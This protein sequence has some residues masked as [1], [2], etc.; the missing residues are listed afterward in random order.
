MATEVTVNVD[1]SYISISD[2]SYTVCSDKGWYW[3]EIPYNYP[4][5]EYTQRLTVD[6]DVD[7]FI[8]DRYGISNFSNYYN[9][10]VEISVTGTIGWT[11]GNL[12]T[13]FPSQ[14]Y[15][16]KL[17]NSYIDIDGYTSYFVEGMTQRT[18]TRN[19]GSASSCVITGCLNYADGTYTNGYYALVMSSIQATITFSPRCS[20][21]NVTA[22]PRYDSATGRIA[23]SPDYYSSHCYDVDVETYAN[24]SGSVWSGSSINSSGYYPSHKTE[25]IYSVVTATMPF[26]EIIEGRQQNAT[27]IT[28]TCTISASYTPNCNNIVVSSNIA[29]GLSGNPYTLIRYRIKELGGSFGSWQSSG[30]FSGTRGIDYVVESA[31][32]LSGD[33]LTDEN[34]VASTL[35]NC[36]IVDLSWTQ[37][38]IVSV[39]G[40]QV[41]TNFT[42]PKP[43]ALS[44]SARNTCEYGVVYQYREG[45]DGDWV[46]LPSNVFTPS[47]VGVWQLRAIIS[48][49]DL[50]STVYSCTL[51]APTFVTSI[52]SEELGVGNATEVVDGDSLDVFESIVNR[53]VVSHTSSWDGA[54][55][56]TRTCTINGASMSSFYVDS[57]ITYSISSEYTIGGVT[58]TT[59]F[60]VLGL[61]FSNGT[62]VCGSDELIPGSGA[63]IE[64]T[65][66]ES[67]VVVAQGW[68]SGDNTYEFVAYQTAVDGTNPVALSPDNGVLNGTGLG[69]TK[70]LVPYS[71]EYGYKV[72]LRVSSTDD[73]GRIRGTNGFI[74]SSSWFTCSVGIVPVVT[75]LPDP[76]VGGIN[77]EFTGDASKSFVRGYDFT[78]SYQWGLYENGVLVNDKLSTSDLTSSEIITLINAVGNYELR[79]TISGTYEDG[80]LDPVTVSLPVSIKEIIQTGIN[81]FNRFALVINNSEKSFVI[82]RKR[83]PYFTELTFE[84][85][86]A[87]IG[88][89][90]CKLTG[91]PKDLEDV[92]RKPGA[93]ITLLDRMNP[94]WIGV[95]TEPC[96]VN[97]NVYN[98]KVSVVQYNIMAYEA[99]KVLALEY[100]PNNSRGLLSGTITEVAES[101]IPPKYHGSIG[102]SSVNYGISLSNTSRLTALDSLYNQ[103]GWRYRCR[104]NT[105]E[106]WEDY[107]AG[108]VLS[109]YNN[110]AMVVHYADGQY[111]CGFA[112]NF[113]SD[114]DG[115]VSIYDEFLIDFRP[116]YYQTYDTRDFVVNYDARNVNEID[117][118]RD[119]FGTAIVYGVGYSGESIASSMK[120]W[121][122]IN[123]DYTIDNSMRITKSYDS[124]IDSVIKLDEVTL[125]GHRYSRYVITMNG[126]SFPDFS[127]LPRLKSYT[128][129]ISIKPRVYFVNSS[130]KLHYIE[131][132]YD[133]AGP[134]PPEPNPRRYYDQANNKKTAYTVCIDQND[135]ASD[136]S[137]R[138]TSV[139]ESLVPLSNII[140][141]VFAVDYPMSLP[142]VGDE[143]CVGD[144]VCNV[145]YKN[146][147]YNEVVV[148][149]KVSA[150]DWQSNGIPHGHYTDVLVMDN[151]G[152]YNQ[153][154]PHPNSPYSQY[155]NT[156]LTT[157]GPEGY[158]I[159]EM[160]RLA[161][162]Y[163]Q[164]GSNYSAEGTSTVSA[165]FFN[166]EDYEFGT[167][168]IPMVGDRIGI[169]SMSE[170]G[171]WVVNQFELQRYVFKYDNYSVE[172]TF[173]MPIL[174][175]GE[176]IYNMMSNS[177]MS[178]IP[179]DS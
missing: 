73:I 164:Y 39:D 166:R 44:M 1:S 99:T 25:Y 72:A 50:I 133:D 135:T 59:N 83:P 109:G 47:S 117:N 46:N 171:E 163:M 111:T 32:F 114:V 85:S 160:E 91:V 159:M 121:M 151:S 56:G 66:G 100:I 146:N 130:N 90:S 127:T 156:S 70:I 37:N 107:V 125:N 152:E 78:L 112:N 126:W 128:Q 9:Y 34:R 106:F 35:T 30:T 45:S 169:K 2:W 77:T 57:S 69:S 61:L 27:P 84:K 179:A 138:V 97:N 122:P 17:Y 142:D 74:M 116:S 7:S 119:K 63:A 36:A 95:I 82:T 176:I 88:S 87:N 81:D 162:R 155:P 93:Y 105:L 23:T 14:S 67:L 64:K 136:N 131:L 41:A 147:T 102:V 80:A 18:R 113:S 38:L 89:L 145:R 21:T 40:S 118:I 168:R 158:T 53:V 52:Y 24:T 149:Y 60:T 170:S 68:G 92:L 120:A 5:G 94:V 140:F 175:L 19:I 132:D 108:S 134:N 3:V 15:A 110:T 150:D 79:C 22:N 33:T 29:V 177:G 6:V 98:K 43:M 8:Y 48:G 153:S 51:L 137:T 161:C 4:N 173:G 76:Y 143:I 26:G 139:I 12:C 16:D 20:I 49:Y 172:M 157:Q 101:I 96:K 129:D 54:S 10:N 123:K 13:Y 103:A 75:L 42:I 178:I 115:K 71:A 104:P 28:S 124:E 144:M 148:D 174:N 141:P 62:V 58:N 65:A 31:V 154:N 86:L 11:S 55:T 165:V 167:A